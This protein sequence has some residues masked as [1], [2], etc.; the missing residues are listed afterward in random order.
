MPESLKAIVENLARKKTLDWTSFRDERISRVD[1]KFS[2]KALGRD[3]Q[4]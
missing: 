3:Y 2:K 4:R 1:K